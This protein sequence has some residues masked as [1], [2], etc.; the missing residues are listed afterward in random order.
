MSE[1]RR[2]AGKVQSLCH[3]NTQR[4]FIFKTSFAGTKSGVSVPDYDAA[5]LCNWFP[6]FRDEVESQL[7]V[8][9]V[10]GIFLELSKFEY[11]TPKPSGNVGK[12][13][14]SDIA[15]YSRGTEC[16]LQH[17]FI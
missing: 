13:L 15:S 10:S 9:K 4:F 3:P 12:K 1:M 14:L 8:S 2:R 5:S 6:I 16:M 17:L 7:Q 11:E